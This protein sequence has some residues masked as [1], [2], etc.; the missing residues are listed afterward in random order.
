[1]CFQGLVGSAC[2][3]GSG[4]ESGFRHV[5]CRAHHPVKGEHPDRAEGSEVGEEQER[6]H[7]HPGLLGTLCLWLHRFPSN[8]GA[9]QNGCEEVRSPGRAGCLQRARCALP[10]PAAA[11]PLLAGLRSR[12]APLA[13]RG[14]HK[15]QFLGHF[16]QA[17]VPCELL[18]VNL[19]IWEERKRLESRAGRGKSDFCGTGG[20]E[21]FL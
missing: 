3:V 8:S 7:R 14:G 19:G 2:W 15:S 21:A 17:S 18:R 5:V 20:E 10:S 9:A 1:V 11:G 13:S 4:P 12:F 6:W 16:N